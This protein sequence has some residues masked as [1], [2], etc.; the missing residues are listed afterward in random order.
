MEMHLPIKRIQIR[1]IFL[2]N[3]VHKMLTTLKDEEYQSRQ[4]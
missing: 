3:E 4:K 1:M 2:N